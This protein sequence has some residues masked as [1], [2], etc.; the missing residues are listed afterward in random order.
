MN[1]EL[2]SAKEEI[3]RILKGI[4]RFV[5]CR[6]IKKRLNKRRILKGIERYK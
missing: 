5:N 3:R 2:K 6:K 1:K 4:E